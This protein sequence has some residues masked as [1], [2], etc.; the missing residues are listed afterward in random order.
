MNDDTPGEFADFDVDAGADFFPDN[1]AP[2]PE[3]PEPSE[4][5]PLDVSDLDLLSPPG[6]VGQVA[7]WIDAQCRYPRRRLA[8]ATALVSCG[9]IG[10][11]RHVDERGDVTANMLAF[12]VS[13]SATGKEAVQQAAA[14]LHRAAGIHYAVQGGIKSEQEI[15]RNL[16]DHQA[17]FYIVDEIGIFLA[18]VRNAQ[19]R[20]GAAYL[21]GV[22][23]AIMATYS[24]ANG[25]LLLQGDTKREL[26]RIYG[27]SLSKAQDDGDAGREEAAQRMLRMVDDGLERPFLS[28]MGFTTPSTFDGSMD[29]ET[30]TQG[31]VGRAIVVNEPDINPSPRLGF[32]KVKMPLQMAM[33]LSALSGIE[34]GGRV[35]YFGDKVEIRTNPDADEALDAVL[36]WLISYAD[37]MHEHA[38]EAAVAMIRRSFEMV[39]KISFILSIPEGVRT[40]EH[41]RWAFAY[42]RAEVDSKVKLVFANDNAKVRPEEAIAARALNMLDPEKGTTTGAIANRMRLK[43]ADVEPILEKMAE[44]NL[45]RFEYSKNTRQGKKAKRWYPV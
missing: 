34:P 14:T 44:Q 1:Y 42:V 33:R 19:K 13:A 18:K 28:V 5:L 17:A 24:K 11:L 8:V 20:G 41:V 12:C 36:L 26:R 40:L 4:T 39:S 10:G 9:N 27:A 29:G 25:N 6:F 22:F 35:E 16:L 2:E 3:T 31:F 30:A 45:V 43:A 15:M 23:A 7:N 37:E 38:G 32:R 21:E